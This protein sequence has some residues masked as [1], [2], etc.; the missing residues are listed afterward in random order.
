MAPDKISGIV[1]PAN[2][3]SWFI[4][5]VFLIILSY[6]LIASLFFFTLALADGL[7]LEFEWQ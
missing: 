6:L 7:S 5:S 3:D 4:D 2:A 1:V